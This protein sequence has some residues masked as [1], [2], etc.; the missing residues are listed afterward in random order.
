VRTLVF[1]TAGVVLA[2][3]RRIVVAIQRPKV[4]PHAGD[5]VFPESRTV[6]KQGGLFD[7]VSSARE[8]ARGAP[9]ACGLEADVSCI[10]L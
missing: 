2:Q 6:G 4:R 5:V 1:K 9:A 7:Y 3:G 10:L 8:A